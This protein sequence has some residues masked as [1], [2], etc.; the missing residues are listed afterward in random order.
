MEA[1]VALD[2]T[3]RE[4]FASGQSFGDVGGYEFLTGRAHF[5]VDPDT[6]EQIGIVD[7]EKAPRNVDGMVECAADLCI[8]KPVDLNKGNRAL[9]F[10]F[11]NR[12]NKRVLQFFDDAPHSNKPR[13]LPDAGNG[14]LMKRGYTIAWAAWQGDLLPGDERLLLEVPV[15]TLNGSPITGLVRA[16]FIADKAGEFCYPLSG[17]ASTRSYPTVNR[18]P[19]ASTFTKRQY[20]REERKLVPPAEWQYARLEL[21]FKGEP[22]IVPSDSYIYLAKGFEP[23]WIYEL[24]YVAKDPLILGLGHLVIRELISYLRYGTTDRGGQPNPLRQGSSG[25]EKAYCWGRSQAGRA[26]RD[27]IFRGFNADSEGRRVFDGAFPHV[28]GAGR[29]WLNHR[30]AQPTRLASLQ[31]EDHLYYADSFPFS[32]AWSTDHLTGRSDAILKR[33]ETDPL[34]IH[35]QTST[36]YWQRRGSLVHTDTQGNDL[37]QPE[38]VRVYLWASSQHWADPLQE[39]PTSSIAQQKSNLVSTSALFRVLIDHLDRWATSG[40]LPPRSRI[41]TRAEGSLVSMAEW[42]TQFP[43]IPGVVVPS[44]PN[45]LRLYDYG[46]NVEEG[47]ITNEP[48]HYPK[49]EEQYNILLPAVD[50]DGNEIAGIR[51]PMI[52]APVATYMGW[53]IRARRFSPGVLAGFLGSCIPFPETKAEREATGDPRAS[54]D[55]R[56]PTQEDHAKALVEAARRLMVEGFLLEED[57]GQIVQTTNK[58]IGPRLGV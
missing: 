6:S 25:M 52:Q 30:F 46:P 31:H 16:E 19:T 2:W 51:M 11:C 34:I 27:F 35:T 54:V 53:N 41:P 47:Y 32:Y 5:E 17:Y 50:A 29:I 37:P 58:R 9:L 13:T 4:P 40:T 12:G 18:D 55:E 24:V 49:G 21:D 10:E 7:L 1:Q 38:N 15:A 45:L 33:P 39:I 26:I 23:G 22:A 14:F 43:R 3:S 36:E 57:F 28:A 56:Y 48:P 42:I 20:V 8:L 44:E